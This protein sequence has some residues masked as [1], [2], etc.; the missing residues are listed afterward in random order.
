M[1]R[2]RGGK[3]FRLTT[4][5]GERGNDSSLNK[6]NIQCHKCKKPEC[7]AKRTEN[8]ENHARVSQDDNSKTLLLAS[9]ESF[10]RSFRSSVL[11][12]GMIVIKVN[13]RSSNYIF[14]VYYTPNICQNLLSVGHLAEKAYDL[15]F[16]KHECTI[17]M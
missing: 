4:K 12:K 7:R 3:N 16:N 17:V 9:Y 11:G 14:E 10:G 15:C 1:E 13:H 6:S 2:D 8:R 5:Q